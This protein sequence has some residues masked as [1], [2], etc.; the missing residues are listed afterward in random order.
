MGIRATTRGDQCA[1]MPRTFLAPLGGVVRRVTKDIPDCR[2]PLLQPLGSA[3]VVGGTGEGA[4]S[5]PRQPEVAAAD[6]QRQFPAVPPAVL[7]GRAPGGFGIERSMRDCAGPPMFLVPAT[8]VG[9]PGR[10]GAMRP[11][12]AGPEGGPDTQSARAAAPAGVQSVVPR[13][14]AEETA[15]VQSAGDESAPRRDQFV[16]ES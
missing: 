12:A 3:H 8:P 13:Y 11:A 5:S 1:G 9:A 16:P 2:R 15:R 7:P 4:R 10:T 6:R 14:A